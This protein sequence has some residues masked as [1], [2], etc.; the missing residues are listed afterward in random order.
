MQDDS[1]KRGRMSVASRTVTL[2]DY[3]NAVEGQVQ[4]GF[5]F[6]QVED[7]INACAIGED[8]KA[9]LWLSA[10]RRQPGMCGARS[11]TLRSSISRMRSHY[12]SRPNIG[13]AARWVVHSSVLRRA[14]RSL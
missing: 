4:A 10:W 8:K 12:E 2:R 9:A 3:Q 1:K 14:R 7:F 13:A 11:P 6:G 5:T